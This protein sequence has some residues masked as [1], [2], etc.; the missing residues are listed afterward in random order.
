MVLNGTATRVALPQEPVARNGQ[1]VTSNKSQG[2][3]QQAKPHQ[4]ASYAKAHRMQPHSDVIRAGVL[5]NQPGDA[6]DVGKARSCRFA[7]HDLDRF[8]VH[9]HLNRTPML[10]ASTGSTYRL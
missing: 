9:V 10:V 8:T 1:Q 3:K 4:Q 5:L 7:L 2:T 6:L